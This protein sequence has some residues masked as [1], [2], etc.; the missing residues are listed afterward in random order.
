MV[1]PHGTLG[2]R[3]SPGESADRAS[4]NPKFAFEP[5]AAA[6]YSRSEMVGA[7]Q[8]IDPD[9]WAQAQHQLKDGGSAPHPRTV[10]VEASPLAG[11]CFDEFGE[12]LTPSHAV[13]D[14]GIP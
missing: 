1:P 12:R 8:R 10:K 9:L 11:K 2:N 6:R 3:L 5:D 7:S 13:K 4:S 14:E